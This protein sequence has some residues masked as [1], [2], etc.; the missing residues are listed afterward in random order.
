MAINVIPAGAPQD[1]WVQIATST[2]TSGSSISF[3]SISPSWRKLWITSSPKYSLGSTGYV[4]VQV[5]SI[6]AAN[7]YI[8]FGTAGTTYRVNDELGIYNYASAA[9]TSG[10]I[11][12][13]ITNKGN[14]LPYATFEGQ[15]STG[16]TGGS[17]DFGW[18]PA[19]TT[20]I[21][22]LDVVTSTTFGAINAGA[23]TLYGTY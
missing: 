10:Y 21:T 5:N 22:Q 20:S 16:G 17:L 7:S 23:F 2:P 14:S 3:T 19:L 15:G 8:W 6:T 13:Y 9:D 18:I 1:N 12:F 11:N 4:Y